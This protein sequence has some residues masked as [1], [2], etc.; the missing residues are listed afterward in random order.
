M[1]RKDFINSCKHGCSVL[2]IKWGLARY[3]VIH[4]AFVSEKIDALQM[5]RYYIPC[6][7]NMRNMTTTIAGFG[8]DLSDAVKS[9]L[10]IYFGCK[11][12]KLKQQLAKKQ[13]TQSHNTDIVLLCI[14]NGFE[15]TSKKWPHYV[16]IYI[17]AHKF[18][19]IWKDK[20]AKHLFNHAYSQVRLTTRELTQ[21]RI[22]REPR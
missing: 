20:N 17:N 10:S 1:S 12:D 6:T 22:K 3:E 21:S 19:Y 4:E 11:L 7:G 14:S 18:T 15:I 16:D 2:Y 13:D 5:V 8:Y 9:A